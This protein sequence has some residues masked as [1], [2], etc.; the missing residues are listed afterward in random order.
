MKN[1]IL[2]LII[3]IVNVNIFAQGSLEGTITNDK[4]EKVFNATIALYQNGELIKGVVTDFDGFYFVDGLKAGKYQL[5]VSYL[6]SNSNKQDIEILDKETFAYST[7]L[8]QGIEVGIIDIVRPRKNPIVDKFNPTIKK[9]K[10]E[11]FTSSG[12]KDINSVLALT[13]GTFETSD[14]K[15]SYRGSRPGNAKYYVDGIPVNS[16]SIPTSAIYSMA[17]YNGGIPARFG[18]TTSAV[19]DIRTKSSFDYFE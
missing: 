6:G 2:I 1:L 3:G 17:I 18:N 11:I 8:I 7:T 13:S 4:N 16:L 5:A 10:A 9:M 12:K 14:G 19:I 15:I